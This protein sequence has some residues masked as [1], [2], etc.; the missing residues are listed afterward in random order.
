[1]YDNK[2]DRIIFIIKL[3]IIYFFMISG[4][5]W[6]LIDRYQELMKILAG[7]TIILL[8]TWAIVETLKSNRA[9]TKYLIIIIFTMIFTW[10]LELLSVNTGFPFGNY[11]YIN[12][13]QPQ[14]LN[15]P[16][17][18]AFAWP[19]AV[20]TSLS[21]AKRLF[22]RTSNNILL[23]LLSALI[24][25]IFD[26]FLE[27][28]AISELYWAWDATWVPISNFITWFVIG[29]IVSYIL[30]INKEIELPNILIHFYF[31]QIAYFILTI[32]PF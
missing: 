2:K 27:M 25:V 12:T 14:I 26:L 24:I 7:P 22:S 17:A 3:V 8:S 32:I 9:Y 28:A 30:L 23:S 4:G 20:L 11:L 1:M 18:I 6:N 19:F 15:I 29:F 16:I 31:A 13:L 5:V 10:F 21:I